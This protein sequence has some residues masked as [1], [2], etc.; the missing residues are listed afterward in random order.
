MK[1]FLFFMTAILVFT[2]M[3]TSC[4]DKKA[5]EVQ[6]KVKQSMFT[7]ADTTRV[8]ELVEQF[9]NCLQ[10]N[11]IK[12]AI[13]MLVY[14]DQDSIKPLSK[15]NI[16]RQINALSFIAGKTYQLDRIVM[17]DNKR[18]EAKIDVVLFEKKEGDRRP[19]TTSFYLR[20][21]YIDGQWYLTT[22]DNVTN[23]VNEN[24]AEEQVIDMGEAKLEND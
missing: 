13:E 11:D 6:K 23:T 17:N 24:P 9:T 15:A 8:F 21:V 16:Q 4:K 14:L 18:N 5:P 1:K 3:L 10:N 2:G 19:N 7:K 22:R 20:P 12:S